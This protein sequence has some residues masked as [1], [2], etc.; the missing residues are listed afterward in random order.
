[1]KAI[2]CPFTKI[3]NGTTQFV[4]PVFQRDYSWTEPQCTQ[5]WSDVLRAATSGDERGHFLG[6]V[7]YIAT[8]DSLAGFTRWLLI[9][10]QQ[11]LTTLT[12][13]LTA[14]RDHIRDTHWEGGENDPTPKR[15]DA[16]FLK[17][18]QEEGERERKLVLRRHDQATLTALI[19]KRELPNEISDRIRENYDFFR[20]RLSDADPSDVYRGISRLVIVDVALDR[21]TDDPQLIFESLN[22]TGI[23]L[24]QSDLIRNF[25]L[26]RLPEKEQTTLYEAYWSKIESLFTGSEWI[27]DTFARDYVALKIQASKQE[28]ASEIYYAFRRL[29]PELRD[30]LG[31][32]ENALVDMLLF[33]RYYA[34][35]SLGRGVTGHIAI[36]LG[37]VRHLV[38]VP[39][40]LVMR[41]YE[42]HARMQSLSEQEFLEALTLVESYVLR[43]AVCGYQ[44]RGYWQIFANLAYKIG[45]SDPLNDLKV[46]LA[47]LR[48]SYR[49]PT[50]DEFERELKEGDLYGLR[51]CRDLLDRLENHDSNEPTDTSGYSIEH[52]L[53]QNERL[54]VAWR[55][56]LDENWREVQKTWLHRL[57]NLTLTGY[58]SKYSDRSFEE[59]KTIKGGFSESSVRLNKFVREQSV[60]TAREIAER[61]NDLARRSLAVWPSLVVAQSLVDD[62]NLREM[63][64]LAARRDVSK[65]KMSVEATTLFVELRRHVL[66]L[67]SEILELAEP[68]SVSYHDPAFFLEVLPRRYTLTLL[69]ALDFNEVD[70]PPDL[71]QDATQWKFFVHAKYEGG[72]SLSVGD[73]GAIETAMPIIRQA[74]AAS[75][76]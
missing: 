28:K 73:E 66:E 35:F 69:L 62:A 54:S 13:L 14:L 33:A 55:T 7:V 64:E 25:I 6:S 70:D 20:D 11:R 27:F 59:K 23:D 38:D 2:D 37:R 49:F 51:V 15:I 46:E 1:M 65:V 5:L 67:G 61:T 75:C 32:M 40:I 36:H 41:L 57:G 21:Q 48:E 12:L 16:Y 29:F 26:M 76:G 50:D 58:K 52:I 56:M 4:I 31:S 22:S 8:G 19:D 39:A 63:R 9:D 44:T 72:V 60:W 53:P 47:R 42:C 68:N 18:V 17:N 30:K 43:R 3:I 71:V 34:A 45:D 10:G 74:H 24:S